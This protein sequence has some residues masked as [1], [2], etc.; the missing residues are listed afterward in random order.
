MRSVKARDIIG[1]GDM[2]I[3]NTT[4]ST[5]IAAVSEWGSLPPRLP[6]GGTGL[7]DEG[8]ERKISAVEKA[9]AVNQPRP[10]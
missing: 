8:L 2:G 10:V 4:P 3:G 9:I 5:A 7:D 6:A 1:T